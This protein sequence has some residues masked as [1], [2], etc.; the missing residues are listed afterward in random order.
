MSQAGLHAEQIAFWDGPGG[1]H[2]VAE[3]A[4]MEPALAPVGEAVLAHAAARLG[5]SVL[6]VGCGYGVTALRLAEAVGPAGRVIGLDVSAPMLE[7]A[8][9]R[10]GGIGNVEWVKDDATTHDFAP[11]SIDLVFSRFGVMFFGD[12]VAAF[13]NLRR[14]MRPSGRLVFACWR[15][16]EENPWIA[17]PAR[18]VAAHVTIP[19]RPGPEDPGMLSF[20]DPARVTRILTA[21]GFA[22]PR[23]TKFDIRMVIGKGLDDATQQALSMRPV[24]QAL[25]TQPEPVRAAAATSVRAALA[26]YAA[27]N[28][29]SLP[30][31]VWLVDAV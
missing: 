20:A 15:A 30:G 21:A 25:D 28:T 9:K 11:A 4:R 6:D 12:P 29:V 13:A 5:E 2:W 18:A 22:A 14:A 8:R 7:L 10:A 31:A 17:V 24:R 26:P 27:G 23:F 1:E 3:Q 19:P 16:I